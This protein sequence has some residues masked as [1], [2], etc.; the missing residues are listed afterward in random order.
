[1]SKTTAV[2][3]VALIVWAEL[4]MQRQVMLRSR[5]ASLEKRAQSLEQADRAGT[6]E[7]SFVNFDITMANRGIKE[8]QSA[9]EARVDTVERW[10]VEAAVAGEAMS[11]AMELSIKTDGATLDT[12]ESVVQR[13]SALEG[14]GD[15]IWLTLPDGTPLKMDLSTVEDLPPLTGPIE[16]EQNNGPDTVTFVP[17]DLPQSS[18]ANTKEKE[19]TK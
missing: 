13:L 14:D 16:I 2:C 10:L 4:T 12:L 7:W 18:D 3:C 5:I 19:P 6:S 8:K 1:M 11:K 9:L 15:V 17:G